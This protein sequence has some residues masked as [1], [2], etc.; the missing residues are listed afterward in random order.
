[1][2][3][4]I[5]AYLER[6][7]PSRSEV[8]YI[9]IPIKKSDYLDDDDPRINLTKLLKNT[10]PEKLVALIKIHEKMDAIIAQLGNRECAEIHIIACQLPVNELISISHKT[11]E[12]YQEI[13]NF[14]TK[15]NNEY[16]FTYI[17]QR[18]LNYQSHFF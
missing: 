7:A 16:E 10:T 2:P 1:M 15:A 9:G 6:K 14:V 12:V 17:G 4:E 11:S 13:Y 18:L 5:Y 3:V 8:Q